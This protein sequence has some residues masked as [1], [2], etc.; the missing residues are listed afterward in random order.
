MEGGWRAL[1]AVA[2]LHRVCWVR[3]ITYTAHPAPQWIA[4]GPDIQNLR[5]LDEIRKT[6]RRGPT[7]PVECGNSQ[8]GSP[9]SLEHDIGPLLPVFLISSNFLRF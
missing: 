3:A 7:D 2:T 9:A 5:N 4:M 6:G 1:L 8:Q